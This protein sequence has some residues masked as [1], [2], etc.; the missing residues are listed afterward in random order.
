[1]TVKELIKNLEQVDNKDI[2]V[3]VLTENQDFRAV[4]EVVVEDIRYIDMFGNLIEGPSKCCR[5][6]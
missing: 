1:M 2:D 4:D 5:L 6:R 3:I